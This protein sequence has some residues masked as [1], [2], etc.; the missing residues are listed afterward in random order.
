MFGDATKKDISFGGCKT[1][2]ELIIT[3]KTEI[4]ST[5][6]CGGITYGN[7]LIIRDSA[8]ANCLFGCLFSY[9]KWDLQSEGEWEI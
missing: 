1:F 2:L 5:N 7:E 3:I 8:I 9:A 6:Q 4:K